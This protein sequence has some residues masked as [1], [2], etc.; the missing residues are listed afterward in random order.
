MKGLKELLL[1]EQQRL[2][3]I[4]ETTKKNLAG[5]PTGTL[6]MSKSHDKQQYYRCTKEKKSGIY[7]NQDN[8][9]MARKLAQKAY[10][11][12]VLT[13]A[14]KRLTQIQRITKDYNEDEIEEIYRKERTE[15]QELIV[16]I[17]STWEQRVTQWK[18]KAYNSKG[19]REDTPIILTEKGERVRSK[20]EKILADYFYR[21]GIEY[22]YEC[23]LYLKSFGTIYPDFTFLSPK[24]GKEIYWEHNG[25]VDDPEYARNM[26]KKIQMY[27]NNGIFPGENLILT[28][29]T[30]QT[31]L[32]TSKIEQLVKRY[33]F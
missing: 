32:N 22:K 33:L 7:I 27:E 15:R 16:P 29:E 26:V 8:M 5:A 28:Y 14:E 17:E 18:T 19:F 10:D 21:K 4:V 6:R 31:I 20:S 24:T 23:P 2:E 9:E 13:L 3:K 30:E 12:K 11:E 1:K 25:K